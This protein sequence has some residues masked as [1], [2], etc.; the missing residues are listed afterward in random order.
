MNSFELTS[1]L[2][3]VKYFTQ[4]TYFTLKSIL[5]P[6]DSHIVFFIILS[7]IKQVKEEDILNYSPS[8][9]FRGTT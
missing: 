1:S 8:V 9:M 6:Y 2:H 5:L 7:S 4:L 3:C